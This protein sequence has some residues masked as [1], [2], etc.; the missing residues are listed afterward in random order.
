MKNSDK[1]KRWFTIHTPVL[2]QVIWEIKWQILIV[3][4]IAGT[5]IT[6]AIGVGQSLNK[7]LNPENIGNYFGRIEKGY[8]QANP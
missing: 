3:L 6:L 2:L 8:N 4:I 7:A 1:I 5:F